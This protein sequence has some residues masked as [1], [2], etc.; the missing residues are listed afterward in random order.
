VAPV[1][2]FDYDAYALHLGGPDITWEERVMEM[3]LLQERLQDGIIR[4]RSE[5]YILD[6]ANF[7]DM[8]DL[9]VRVETARSSYGVIYPYEVWL[10]GTYTEAQRREM[11]AFLAATFGISAPRQ[12]W[13]V[14]NG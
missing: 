11:E 9:T 3:E 12:H 14:A 2:D 10:T 8:G 7:L 4:E 1:L 6:K 13:S 5:A